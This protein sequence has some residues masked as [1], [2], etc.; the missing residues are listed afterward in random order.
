MKGGAVT[1]SD[2]ASAAAWPAADVEVSY[3][4]TSDL[5]GTTW[6][7]EEIN[8]AG[9]GVAISAQKSSGGGGQKTAYI[10]HIKITITYSSP[11]PVT[12]T[13]F[14]AEPENGKV[15][16]KWTTASEINNDFFTVERSSNGASFTGVGTVKGAGNSTASKDYS[17]IDDSPLKGTSYYRLKQTDLDGKFEYFSIIAVQNETIN[18]DCVFKVY[19]NPCMGRC[20]VKLENCPQNKDQQ[21]SVA[22]IDMLGNLVYSQVPV[23]DQ[24]GSFDFSIDVNNNLKPGIY[25]VKASSQDENYEQK[26]IINSN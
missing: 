17:L 19:P 18:G 24:D 5:W 10:D 12:L 20:G 21:I 2:K 1:G 4:G 14:T 8:D 7:A 13:S 16:L 3:G 15:V 25:I 26:V 22:V 11:L 9:F 23:R 6:T